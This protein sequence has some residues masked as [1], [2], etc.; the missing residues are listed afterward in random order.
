MRCNKCGML[1]DED[2]RF[3]ENCGNPITVEKPTQNEN[4]STVVPPVVNTEVSTEENIQS[5]VDLTQ[6]PEQNFNQPIEQNVQTHP[7]AQSAESVPEA[8][9]EN[10]YT[11]ANQN[12]QNNQNQAPTQQVVPPI[13]EQNAL[14]A[15]KFIK[16]TAKKSTFLILTVIFLA[17][18]IVLSITSVVL[19][20]TVTPKIATMSNKEI[21]TKLSTL[22]HDN[23]DEAQEFVDD[24]DGISTK[25]RKELN[26]RISTLKDK[27]KVYKDILDILDRYYDKNQVKKSSISSMITSIVFDYGPLIIIL[28]GLMIFLFGAITT[29]KK[30]A[31]SLTVSKIGYQIMGIM[32]IVLFSIVLLATLAVCG[33]CFAFSGKWMNNLNGE[34]YTSFAQIIKYLSY[35]CIGVAVV[36]IIFFVLYIVFYAKL[37]NNIKKVRHSMRTGLLT[38]KMSVYVNVML[39]IVGIFG[40]LCS[41]GGIFYMITEYKEISEWADLF[42]NK[43]NIYIGLGGSLSFALMQICLAFAFIGYKKKVKALKKE[44][45]NAN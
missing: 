33:V 3:C 11:K 6:A 16:N 30:T 15:T 41:A 19:S 4:L 8:K 7:Q 12:L 31:S 29:S 17:L 27:D 24:L 26:Y 10:P 14:L 44:T 23:I 18:S 42:V 20:Y 5:T 39:L 34:G 22:I 43:I 37:T 36:A 40:L 38:S 32:R 9:T 35:I 28:I 25:E 13:T 45:E 21:A 2:A 1:N